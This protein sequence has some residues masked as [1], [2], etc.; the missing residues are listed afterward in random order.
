MLLGRSVTYVP[1]SGLY[2]IYGIDIAERFDFS[3]FS[4]VRTP[5][6]PFLLGIIFKLFGSESTFYMKVIQHLFNLVTILF[7]FLIGRRLHASVWFAWLGTLTACFSLQLWSFASLPMTEVTY[8]M[9]ATGTLYF[10]I[11]YAQSAKKFDLIGSFLLTGI[12]TLVRP[13]AQYLVVI[14]FCIW[15]FHTFLPHSWQTLAAKS[16]PENAGKVRGR[17]IVVLL[18]ALTAY[19]M[20]IL[21]WMYHNKFYHDVFSMGGNL[22]QN[23]FSRVVEQDRL[24]DYDSAAIREIKRTYEEEKARR[25]AQGGKDDSYTWMNHH[26]SMNAYMQYH[27]VTMS[28]AD[29]IFLRAALDCIK[30]HPSEYFYNTYQGIIK[31]FKTYEPIFLYIPGVETDKPLRWPDNIMWDVKNINT[32]YEN[33]AQM[34]NKYL[35]NYEPPNVFTAIYSRMVKYYYPL[36]AFDKYA[37]IFLLLQVLG[38]L[39]KSNKGVIVFHHS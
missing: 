16:L 8:T 28:E 5:G 7:V 31:S 33:Y 30:K 17:S 25:L 10:Y 34:A 4:Y 9:M 26:P 13:Q 22:G 18:I 12:S 14:P 24:I 27:K 19:L 20:C 15:G 38:I 37:R 32:Y 11:R 1:D 3:K 6:Y 29:N 2:V 35:T 39:V 21:P 36:V 23:L